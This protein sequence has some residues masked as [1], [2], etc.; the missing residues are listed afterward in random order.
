MAV[1]SKKSVKPFLVKVVICVVISLIIIFLTQETI[2]KFAP[3]NRIELAT[4]DYRFNN[5]GSIPYEP[6]VVVI[7]ISEE[8]FK[9]VPDKWPWPRSYYAKLVRNL[10]KAGARAIGI[11]VIMGGED[12]RNPANDEDFRKAIKE[13]GIV[14]LAGKVIIADERY[15]IISATN[16]YGNIFFDVDSSI[17]NVYLRNDP[18]GVYRR[19]HPIGY[20]RPRQLRLPSFALAVLNKAFSL[21]PFQTVDVQSDKFILESIEIPSYDSFSALINYYGPSRTFSPVKFVDVID[22]ADFQTVEEKELGVDINTFDDPESGYLYDGTFKDKIVLVGSTNP[23]DKDLFPVPVAYGKQEGDN[24]MYGVEIHANIIQSIL[25]KNFLRPTPKWL[26]L[27]FIFV[28]VTFTFFFILN[29]KST[30]TKYHYFVEVLALAVVVVEL[31]LIGTLSIILFNN[32]NTIVSLTGPLLAVVFGYVGSMVYSYVSERKQKFMIKTMF[33]QYVSP[34]VVNELIED[35]SKLQLGGERKVLT[36]LF[37]DLE[38]FTSI[39]ERM[40]PDQLIPLLN[41]YFEGMTDIILQNNGT[42]DKYIGDSIMAFYGAPIPL[43]DH[44]L[45]ACRTA[46]QM[47]KHLDN[48]RTSQQSNDRPIF[49]MRIGINTGEMVVGNLGGVDRF[50]YTVIGDSVNLAARLEGANK[51]Y[52]TNI[53][54]SEYTFHSVA[55]QVITRELDLITVLGKTKPLKIYELMG[56]IDDDLHSDVLKV[57]EKFSESLALYRQR[58]WQKAIKKFEEVLIIKPHDY[59]SKC[60]IERSVSFLKI[61]PPEDWDGVFVM[62]TK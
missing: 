54:I 40:P 38:D 61:P 17:G 24:L 13:V 55:S 36:V 18:D 46:I 45:S 29:L 31:F 19:Y 10:K 34:T 42:L 4:I 58:E 43:K 8:S 51:Q 20:D 7:G 32:Q 16:N 33:S 25:D 6:K 53:L 26:E 15:D 41:D 22:D 59:P 1:Q 5:R 2:F 14:T 37:T 44:A 12:I 3:L 48:I 47:Q 23:E 49:K 56:L 28:F 39:A 27:L 50:D 57:V 35:P 62:K 9:S 21:H 52:K 11:D 30:K 60:Y